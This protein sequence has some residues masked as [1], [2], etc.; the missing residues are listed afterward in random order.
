[1][2]LSF[3]FL[4]IKYKFNHAS[5]ESKTVLLGRFP[6]SVPRGTTK[7]DSSS[8]NLWTDLQR[9]PRPHALQLLLLT[10]SIYII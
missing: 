7:I 4:I 10:N 2:I 6:L 3:L 9:Q 8:W 5:S 1:M